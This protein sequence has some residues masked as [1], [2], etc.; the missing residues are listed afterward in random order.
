MNLQTL[1]D[2]FAWDDLDARVRLVS[3]DEAGDLLLEIEYDDLLMPEGKRLVR[4]RCLQPKE[5]TVT[6]GH[7]GGHRHSCSSHPLRPRR[8]KCSILLTAF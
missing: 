3:L 6:A 7:I 8:Q 5:F 4:L 1:V 2:A